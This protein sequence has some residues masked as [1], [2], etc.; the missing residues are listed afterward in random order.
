MIF[1][2]FALVN[3]VQWSAY[4]S[5]DGSNGAR[6]PVCTEMFGS[7]NLPTARSSRA[8]TAGEVRV[9]TRGMD[10]HVTHGLEVWNRC[11][12]LRDSKSKAEGSRAAMR[13][14]RDSPLWGGPDLANERTLARTGTEI[15]RDKFLA[16]FHAVR[17]DVKSAI[18]PDSTVSG[19]FWEERNAKVTK[20]IKIHEEW[21]VLDCG[22]AEKKIP[23]EGD[24]NL[25]AFFHSFL[26]GRRGSEED[27]KNIAR[28]EDI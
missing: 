16:G 3:Q 4:H 5:S 18:L 11:K 14:A 9:R 23:N 6:N 12:E 7:V 13:L 2:D 22:P 19:G 1:K 26:S 17:S 25:P 28:S 15:S 20:T 24:T 10:M 27:E 8:T 21:T